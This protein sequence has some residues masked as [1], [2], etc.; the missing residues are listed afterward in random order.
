MESA[1]ETVADAIAKLGGPT[2]TG[3]LVGRS[4]QSVVNWR[5]ANKFPGDTYLILS[6]ALE[7]RGLRAP[8]SMWGL[9]EPER[10]AS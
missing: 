7:D 5:A 3:K 9:I 10:A 8:P 6:A 2:A 1:V 4:A